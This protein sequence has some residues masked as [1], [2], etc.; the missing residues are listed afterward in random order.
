MTT[1]QSAGRD[2]PWATV[3]E[4]I[5]GSLPYLRLL[6]K[7]LGETVNAPDGR[8]GSFRQRVE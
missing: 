6:Y 3:G 5:E 2:S 4:A 8:R 1:R 7:H